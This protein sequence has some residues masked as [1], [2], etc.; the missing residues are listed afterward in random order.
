[1]F[2]NSPIGLQWFIIIIISN[3]TCIYIYTYI[4]STLT[5]P[6][7]FYWYECVQHAGCRYKSH[8]KTHSTSPSLSSFHSIFSH[9]VHWNLSHKLRITP[10]TPQCPWPLSSCK[11]C[12]AF[13]PMM[14]SKSPEKRIRSTYFSMWGRRGPWRPWRCVIY[15]LSQR[16][17]NMDGIWMGYGWN[18]DGIWMEYGWDMDGI[19][20]GYGWNMDGIWMEYG[21]DMDGIWMVWD[22]N[23]SESIALIELK[24]GPRTQSHV[25]IRNPPPFPSRYGLLLLFEVWKLASKLDSLAESMS[26]KIQIETPENLFLWHQIDSSSWCLWVILCPRD[27][28]IGLNPSPHEIASASSIKRE[29]SDWSCILPLKL[30]FGSGKLPGMWWCDWVWLAYAGVSKA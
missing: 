27:S 10:M 30:L 5:M 17:I 14:D 15:K 28:I 22:Q 8:N 6:M 25:S 21:W 3:L 18:M 2:N 7:G 24:F 13:S 26:H 11:N 9:F 23:H 12:S 4:H 1:M 19:W 29:T 16:K 20:M